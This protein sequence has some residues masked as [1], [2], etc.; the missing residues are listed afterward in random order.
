MT[1]FLFGG[2]FMNVSSVFSASS[3]VG[4]VAVVLGLGAMVFGLVVLVR[5]LSGGS[6]DDGDGE[7]HAVRPRGGVGLA[8][9]LLAVGALVAVF[10]VGASSGTMVATGDAA[11]IVGSEADHDSLGESKSNVS[12]QENGRDDVPSVSSSDGLGSDG[13]SS[14]WLSG[15]DVSSVGGPVTTPIE[16]T[17]DE[18]MTGESK[19]RAADVSVVCGDFDAASDRLT[20]LMS[21]FG[22]VASSDTTS[23][24]H[25]VD[26]SDPR[27]PKSVD[28]RCRFVSMRVPSDRLDPFL[29]A[30]R[31]DGLFEVESVDL[32][33]VD[34][35]AAK[36]ENSRRRDELQKLYDET[37]AKLDATEDESERSS[38]EGRLR[39]LEKRI[40]AFDEASV[41]IDMSINWSTVNLSLTESLS[42]DL[43]AKHEFEQSLSDVPKAFALGFYRIGTFVLRNLALV[44]VVLAGV[45]ALFVYR[46]RHGH[47]PFVGDGSKSEGDGSDA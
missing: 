16:G 12:G 15:D 40:E 45:V 5:S 13:A 34:M 6:S 8:A 43:A 9:A 4:P 7:G 10:G 17:S 33:S 38:L 20:G 47:W 32:Q 31:N 25:D 28:L 37:K 42:S 22:G 39:T 19:V 14:R 41:D 27:R 23:T 44:L 2:M 36:N 21:E 46:S 30:V 35:T 1:F 24:M 18:D 26:R 11:A 29:S 3:V